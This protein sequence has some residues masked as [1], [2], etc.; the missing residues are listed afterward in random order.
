MEGLPV[1]I[2]RKENERTAGFQ[3]SSPLSDILF[4]ES[5]LKAY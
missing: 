2:E 5:W 4:S 1:R 3:A